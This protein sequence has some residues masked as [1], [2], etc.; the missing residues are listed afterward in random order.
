[1]SVDDYRT[2]IYANYVQAREK[3]LAPRALAGLVPRAPYLRKLIRTHFPADKDAVIIDLGCGHGALIHFARETGYHN[4]RGVDGSAEQ[5]AAA[6]RLGIEGVEEGDVAEALH[7][8]SDASQDVVI[9]FDLIEHF[10][11]AEV[12]PLVDEVFR[13]LKPGGRWIVHVP[14]AEGPFGARIRYSDFTHELAFTRTSLDQLLRASGF[15]RVDCF[16]DRPVPHGLKSFVRAGLWNVIRVQLLFY[17]AVETGV[18]DRKAAFSQNLLAV[19]MKAP[20]EAVEN[21]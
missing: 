11:K 3:P 9:A 12:I 1:M 4:V 15:A 8:T 16:E 19:A 2:R 5:V 13:V 6:E 10:T 18:F 7:N 20:L 14:N 17:T 21:V